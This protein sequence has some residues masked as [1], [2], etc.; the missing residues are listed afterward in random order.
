MEVYWFMKAKTDV[1]KDIQLR[2]YLIW[3]S[4]GRPQG[5]E[6][7]HWRRAEA[8]VLGTSNGKSAPHAKVTAAPM[9]TAAAKA[10]PAPKTTSDAKPGAKAKHAIKPKQK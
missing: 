2:A 7:E 3:E 9:K 4:E 10:A 5:K 6:H 8:E 1:R